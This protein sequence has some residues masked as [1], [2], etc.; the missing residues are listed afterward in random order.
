[1]YYSQAM[2]SSGNIHIR[3]YSLYHHE[4]E[5]HLCT[6]LRTCSYLAKICTKFVPSSS[7]L[8]RTAFFRKNLP[9]SPL[10]VLRFVLSLSCRRWIVAST[11]VSVLTLCA[12]GP[13]LRKTRAPPSAPPSAGRTFSGAVDLLRPHP[14]QLLRRRRRRHQ[15]RPTIRAPK[16]ASCPRDFKVTTAPIEASKEDD[17]M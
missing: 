2:T 10:S 1:M 5:T 3:S 7:S 12:R 15:Q 17:D 4:R 16:A 13:I 9:L 14:G 8:C 6:N 11:A